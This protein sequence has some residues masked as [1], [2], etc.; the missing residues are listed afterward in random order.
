M[1]LLGSVGA[2]AARHRHVAMLAASAG[3]AALALQAGKGYLDEQLEAERARHVAPAVPTESVVVA[4]R[5][6]R[7][8]DLV[9]ADTM[10]V[11]S[12]P[13][14]YAMHGA[15]RPAQFE[16]FDGARLAAPL[17]AGEQ[18]LGAL[19]AG[20]DAA[21]FS[22]RLKPG[23][24]ALTLAVDE[25]NSISG[26]LQPGDRVDLYFSARAP[27]GA[28]AAAGE[29][30][31][32]LQQ[33]LLVL[34]TGRQVRPGGDDR[35]QGA[36]AYSS[37][38]VALPPQAAQRLVVAQRTGRLTAV[39]RHPEDR[40]VQDAASMDLRH[41]FGPVE[42]PGP[43]RFRPQIIVGGSGRLAPAMAPAS[44]VAPG[45]VPVAAPAVAAAQAPGTRVDAGPGSAPVVRAST[46][47]ARP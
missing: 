36:R 32:P 35:S 27:G 16:A 2:I 44:T 1:T 6:L 14:T 7:A 12:V 19:V 38:T 8:G 37:V 39:L 23:I 10:A 41:L 24:R 20:R 9:N 31:V 4:R 5:D 13:R 17:A 33:N 15:V 43:A 28:R 22:A 42:R 40:L 30:T 11:R 25:I 46:A 29:T 45:A 34:A 47:P 26:M 21:S 18:L 3:C